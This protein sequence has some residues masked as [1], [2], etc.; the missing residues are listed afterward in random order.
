M[1]CCTLQPQDPER[2]AL[3]L[4]SNDVILRTTRDEVTLATLTREQKN[5]R[6]LA[7]VESQL[8]VNPKTFEVFLSALKVRIPLADLCRRMEETYCK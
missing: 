1:Y 3:D 5:T 6:I 7:A 4:Y 8:H 2:I